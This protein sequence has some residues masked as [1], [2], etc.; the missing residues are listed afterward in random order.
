MFTAAQILKFKSGPIL[1]VGLLLLGGVPSAWG[2]E[3]AYAAMRA[4]KQQRPELMSKLVEIEGARGAIQ[5]DSWTFLFQ[6]PT[7]RGGV[8]ELILQNGAILS[9]R[10]PLRGYGGVGDL[11]LIAVD[12]LNLDSGGAFQLANQ[13]ANRLGVGFH[14]V[15]YTLRAD[16]G[17]RGALW[18][19]ELIDYLGVPVGHMLVS[20]ETLKIVQPLKLAPGVGPAVVPPR[21]TAS[22][23]PRGGVIGAVEDFGVRASRTVRRTTL[24]VIG[25]VEEWLTGDRTIGLEE[26]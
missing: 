3:T 6:D 17:G 2:G 20:A 19:L 25:S 12:R 18:N 23:A 7:A 4:L 16:A 22:D 8:R 13:E 1:L 21:S 5:P 26:D 10:T 24:N 14:W 9:E 11:P 15:N